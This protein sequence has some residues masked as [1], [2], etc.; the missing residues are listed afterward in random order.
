MSKKMKRGFAI[1]IAYIIFTGFFFAI[2]FFTIPMI[3]DQ[4]NIF[5]TKLPLYIKNLTEMINNFIEKSAIVS[6][7][8]SA[9]NKEVLPLDSNAISTYV[10]NSFNLTSSSIIQNATVFTRSFINIVITIIIG[11]LLGIY[12]LKDSEKLKNLFIRVLPPR[13]KCQASNI[14]ERINNVGGRYIRAQILVSIIV[15]ILCTLILVILKVDF[16]VLLGFI[17]GILN[18][19]PFLG[20]VLGAIPAALTALF[21]SPLKALL[22]VLLFIAVQQLDNYVISPNIMK[23]QVGVHPAIIIF[24]LIAGG[25]LLGPWGLLIAV[26]TTAVLQSVLKYYLLERKNIR[27]R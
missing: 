9:T 12:I 20:P 17:A 10:I 21:I 15:G 25:A 13:L 27:S 14:I 7:I 24:V 2:F 1:L 6:A 5:I 23:Y 26:P 22:V 19:V 3:I 11:P 4:F 16:A 18:L 8:E